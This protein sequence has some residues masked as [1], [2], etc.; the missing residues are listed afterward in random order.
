MKVCLI[1]A[2]D[3]EGGL[4]KHLVELSNCIVKQVDELTVIAH[5]KY[6]QRFLPNIRFIPLDLSRSRRNPLLLCQLAWIL[7]NE[8][9][10]IIH[11]QANKAVDILNRIK[12]FVP[13]IRIG[14]LHSK[15]KKVAMFS[16]MHTVIGVSK[17]VVSELQHPDKRVV[18]NGILP[19][20]GR[21]YSRIELADKFSLTPTLPITLSVGRLVPVKAFDNL[22]NAWQ[23]EFGQLLIVGDGL[24]KNRLAQLIQKRGLDNYVI[25]TGFCSDV[26]EMMSAV[27]LL[28]VPSHREGFSYVVAEALLS[29]LPVLSTRVPVANEILLEQFLVN[30]D[31]VAELASALHRVLTNLPETQQQQTVL[32]DWAANALTVENMAKKTVGI[33]NDLLKQ[34]KP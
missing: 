32:F 31:S 6:R 20:Y 10:D 34:S 27:D 19:C 7:R 15:K 17:G 13:G 9:P 2:G 1:M 29:R 18:Y 23:P 12:H 25:L 28:V 22:I 33:Y 16:G 26:Q 5:E 4:E 21:H 11:A 8:V 30:V 24:E 14:T 3:E